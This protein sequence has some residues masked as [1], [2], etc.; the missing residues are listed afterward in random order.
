MHLFRGCFSRA[1]SRG[2]RRLPGRSGCRA[3]AAAQVSA[4][5][6]RRRRREPRRRG[7]DSFL[8]LRHRPGERQPRRR[9]SVGDGH[10]LQ[11]EREDR[12]RPGGRH[13]SSRT[14]RSSIAWPSRATRRSRATSLR[15]K[16]SPRRAPASTKR[17]PRPTSIASRTPIRRSAA[18]R[19]KVSYR[20]VQLPN[21]RVDLVFTVDEGDKTGV[22]EIKFVGNNAVSDYRL[23]SLMQTTEMNFL[24]W[25]KTTDVY[26]PD[27]LA[28][29]EEAIRK[30][31]MK[32]GYADFRITN[33]DVA[34]QADPAGYVITITVDEG[35]QYHVSRRQRDLARAQGR[36]PF[37]R[38]IRRAARGRRLQRDRRSTRRSIRSRARWRGWATPSPTCARTASATKRRTRSRSPSP[39]TT[40]RRSTSSASTSSAT[41][42]RA[43]T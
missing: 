31:Y 13:A 10:V 42:A 18:T 28:S 20:L 4:A 41:P 23:H 25:F 2:R 11:G 5:D 7:D 22:R 14:R 16:S 15:S 29:D 37:A 21:G 3:P 36:Q 26:D 19:R 12:R 39:S 43:T 33:T 1:P 9:R 40:G 17:R 35:P 34:Y 24:S 27:R 8:F 6:R 32:N 38:S 30:Y